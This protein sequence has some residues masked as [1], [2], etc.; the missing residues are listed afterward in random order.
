MKKVIILLFIITSVYLI[1]QKNEIVIPNDAVRFRIIANSNSFKDQAIK[2][3][4]KKELI[5]NVFPNIKSKED[6][7]TN[8]YNIENI[9]KSYNIKYTINYGMNYFPEKVYK[10]I[11]YPKGNYESLV[12][13]LDEGKGDNFWCVMYPSLCL[14][15]DDNTNDIE[16]KV[17][18]KEI[19]NNYKK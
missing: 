12:V 13:T 14:I 1:N 11:K 5:N 6:I 19:I 16:Y 9:V 18:V 7:K 15:D 3:E 8:I 4:I 10:G 2:K 17:L